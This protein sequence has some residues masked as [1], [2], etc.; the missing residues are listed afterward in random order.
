MSQQNRAAAFVLLSIA[1]VLA[2]SGPALAQINTGRLSGTV[3]D[4]SEAVVAG[5]RIRATNESTGII[6]NATSGE[7]G[8]YL[9]TFLIPGT[10]R[11]EV[12]KAGFQSE[13]QLGV[14]VN[15]G[16]ITRIDF[17]LRVGEVHQ[18]VEV[19]ANVVGVSTE[20]SELSKTFSH[21]DLDELPNIDRNPL[22]QMNVLPGANSGAGSGSY[23]TNGG[24]NGSAVGQTRPQLA[25]IGGVDANANSVYIEGIFNREPQ[26]GYVGLVPPIEGIEEVQVYTGKYNAEY[27]FSGSAVINV[28]TKSGGNEFHGALFEYLRNN[29]TDARNY[30]AVDNTP[31]HRNQFG[32][33]VGGPIRKNKLFF[34]ADYQGTKHNTH[35]PGYTTVPTDKMYNGDFSEIYD[36]SSTDNAGAVSGQIYDPLS[37]VLDSEGN[38]VSAMAFPGNLIPASRYNSAAAKMNAEKIFGTANLPGVD[39]NNYYIYKNTETEHQADGRADYYY[40]DRN[41]FFF[42]Y[43]TLEADSD[44][45]TTV[46]KFYQDGQADSHTVNRNMQLTHMSMVRPNM[47]NEL[48]LGY[49]RT[50]VNTSQKSMD[51]DWNNY[52][53]IVNGN[54]GDPMSQGLANISVSGLHSV[55]EIDWVGFIISNTVALTDNLSWIKGKHNLKFGTSINHVQ[56][57]SS[58]TMGNPRGSLSFSGATTS[59]DGYNGYYGYPS[60]LLGNPTASRRANWISGWPYQTYWQNAWYAQDDFK[61]LPS[62]TLNL[63]LRY[64]RYSNPV[65]RFNRQA[66]WDVRTN[67]LV[68]ATSSNRS[69]SLDQDNGNWGPRVGFAWSPDGGK[70][71][72][73]GGYGISYWQ[74]YWHGPL[75]ILGLTYP[76]FAETDYV[77]TNSLVP[78]LSLTREGI[79][80]ATAEYDSSGKLLIPGNAVIRGSAYNWKN[81][82]VDQATLNLEREIRP[83]M[84][85]DVGYVH[86]QG[87]HNLRAVNANQAAPQPEG[88]DWSLARPLYSTYPQ[89]GDVYVYYSDGSSYYDAVTASFTARLGRSVNLYA[90]YDHARSF[91]NGNNYNPLD[92]DQY[93]GP[94]QNDIAHMFNAQFTV[95]L[96]FGR[97][98]A[99]L[100]NA[101]RVL[102]AVVGGWQYSGFLHLQTGTRFDVYSW[103]SLLNNGQG[104]RPNRTCSGKLSNP[105]PEHWYDTSCFSDQLT[106]QAYGTA[107]VN[108]LTT[109]GISQLD[110]SLSKTFSITERIQLQFRADAFNTFNHT[111]FG[112]PDST[113]G[114]STVGQIFYTSVDQRRMQFGLRLSF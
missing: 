85:L 94:N 52:Y 74:A 35:W 103:V 12:E 50:H 20:T 9:V 40:S 26:N 8:E 80:L 110:S 97:G 91:A 3:H 1:G 112:A 60:F 24:E 63:G 28:V 49:N 46:S 59:Y 11:V 104:N 89:L 31:F 32:A 25:S 47:S 95:D 51:Q 70:T 37:R 17:K 108:P 88:T 10:Y 13:A 67:Q 61:I 54:L 39:N 73:R 77:V 18:T 76:Y 111:D 23:S 4:A 79:P 78:S 43:S 5:A 114:S 64:E 87:R 41:R 99:L 69:P 42:R 84:L 19:A 105:T 2:W 21:K 55:G 93:Y 100:S 58:D 92:I 72:L 33:A 45:A 36:T 102:N 107:G 22:F 56:D 81:Q 38:V 66:N 14:A 65:E 98:R 83:G 6:T 86:V 44:N 113:V 82:R 101:N 90:N 96:P 7:S 27:G 48:R 62:L 75:S 15:A 106:P 53:G 71:S 34:F 109:D 29:K 16:T 57:T 30:F 68:V